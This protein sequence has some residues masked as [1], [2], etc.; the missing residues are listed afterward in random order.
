[1]SHYTEI[2]VNFD[3]KYEK[4]LIAALEEHFGEGNVEVHD[5]AKVLKLWNGV[6]SA[7]NTDW[8][9]T[10]KCNLVITRATQS[11]K[12]GHDVLSNDAGY[13]RTEDG[14]YKAFIDAAGF[15]KGLQGLVSQSYALKVSEKKLKAEGY[16]TKRVVKADGTIRLEA[17]IYS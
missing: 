4:E 2:K 8:G 3:Q 15:N 6:S 13:A 7:Q 1:M 12:V 17:R 14:K 5:D 10:D 16:M 11:K 9:K